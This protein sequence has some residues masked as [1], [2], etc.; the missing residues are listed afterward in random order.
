MQAKT[1]LGQEC[2]GGGVV[3]IEMD[4]SQASWPGTFRNEQ[5]RDS[6][7]TKVEDEEADNQS[8]PLIFTLNP[9]G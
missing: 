5:Q 1:K 6:D 2:A 8:C 4:F 7:S 9:S 3:V